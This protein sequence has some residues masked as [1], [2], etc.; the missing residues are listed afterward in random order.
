MLMKQN[1][2]SSDDDDDDTSIANKKIESQKAELR[3]MQEANE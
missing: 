3:R 1:D 2:S